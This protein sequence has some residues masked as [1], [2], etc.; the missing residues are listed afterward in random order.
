MEKNYNLMNI[1]NLIF[2][3]YIPFV[4]KSSIFYTD[5]QIYQYYKSLQQGD[6]EMALFL[7]Y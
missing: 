1:K 6:G 7:Y 2:F 4:H 3:N 5:I